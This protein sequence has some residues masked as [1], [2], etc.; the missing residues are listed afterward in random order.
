[1]G[2]GKR[3]SRSRPTN[4]TLLR[5]RGYTDRRELLYGLHVRQCLSAL[6]GTT[7]SVGR[8]TLPTRFS[9]TPGGTRG[10]GLCARGMPLHAAERGQVG[11]SPGG[12]LCLNAPS[13]AV[14][15]GDGLWAEELEKDLENDSPQNVVYWKRQGPWARRQHGFPSG[16]GRGIQRPAAQPGQTPMG[17]LR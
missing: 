13:P 7:N 17:N 1:M 12:P 5:R 8:P 16:Q 10:D 2:F 9:F 11:A 6:G 14:T 15:S 4:L 3:A